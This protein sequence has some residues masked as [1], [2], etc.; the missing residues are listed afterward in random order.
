[1][2]SFG[3]SSAG[4]SISAMARA[5]SAAPEFPGECIADLRREQAEPDLADLGPRSPE[6]QKL[7]QVTGPLHHLAGDGAVDGDVLAGD[8]FDDAVIGRGRAPDIVLR[9]QA[10]DGNHDVQM[11]QLGP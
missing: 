4:R 6:L 1:M 2:S 9:L 3:K 7:S 10:V 5:R 8:I 11:R